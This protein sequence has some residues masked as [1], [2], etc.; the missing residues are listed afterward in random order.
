LDKTGILVSTGPK[1]IRV[2]LDNKATPAL[3]GNK[4]QLV[5]VA[6]RESKVQ[7]VQWANKVKL[8]LLVIL[9]PQANRANKAIRVPLAI[10]DPSD[11]LEIQGL[12]ATPAN[13]ALQAIK[14]QQV[15]AATPGNKVQLETM[16]LWAIRALSVIL[17]PQVI[18]AIT[19]IPVPPAIKDPSAILEIQ[20]TRA[21]LADKEERVLAAT[22]V[23]SAT[24]AHK[25]QLVLEGNKATQALSAPLAPRVIK[26]QPVPLVS[27]AIKVPLAMLVI[28]ALLAQL[29][30]QEWREPK[31]FMESRDRLALLVT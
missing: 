11:I 1:A 21:Q 22:R 6:T 27:Q 25:V 9:V 10:K 20:A 28:L 18:K 17:A 31:V 2:T 24:L 16:G 26:V 14:V 12:S 29:A 3:P 7:L 15:P 23:L 5:L 8:D 4:V 13:A 30:L 19:A